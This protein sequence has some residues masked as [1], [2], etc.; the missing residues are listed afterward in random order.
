MS[1]SPTAGS[2]TLLV[3][4]LPRATLAVPAG[5]RKGGRGLSLSFSRFGTFKLR[6]VP[7]NS[8][9]GKARGRGSSLGACAQAVAARKMRL[10]GPRF[11]EY[12]LWIQ[13]PILPP[14]LLPKAGRQPGVAKKESSVLDSALRG[15]GRPPRI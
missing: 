6:G 12:V 14:V 3:T 7:S 15:G 13:A 9:L 4:G 2:I 8:G 11:T 10:A 1:R 5:A